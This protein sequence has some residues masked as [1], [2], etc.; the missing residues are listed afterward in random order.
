MSDNQ[1]DLMGQV[2]VHHLN[3]F[4]EEIQMSLTFNEGIKFDAGALGERINFV[5]RNTTG[6]PSNG[7]CAFDARDG[8]EAKAVWLGQTTTCDNCGAKNNFYR[9]NCF[10][11]FHEWLSSPNDTRFGIDAKAHFTYQGEIPAYTFVEVRPLNRDTLNPILSVTCWSVEANNKQLNAILKHQVDN[12]KKAHKNLVPHSRDWWMINPALQF[13]AVARIEADGGGQ[14]VWEEWTPGNTHGEA[15]IP[16]S[17][18]T[19]KEKI[20]LGVTGDKEVP[21]DFAWETLGVKQSTHG[22][23]RGVLNRNRNQGRN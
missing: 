12:G 6:Q 19:A 14:F 13:R 4:P 8:S 1:Q 9:S 5:L 3:N 20:K 11:C 15:Q 16:T 2:I 17:V 18:F 22:R 23:E 10:E 21:H 7:G